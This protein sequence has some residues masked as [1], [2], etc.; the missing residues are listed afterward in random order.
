LRCIAQQREL[1]PMERDAEKAKWE[2]RRAEDAA[3][4][5]FLKDAITRAKSETAAVERRK[6]EDELAGT[7]DGIF[8]AE[9]QAE[10][11][12]TWPDE[13]TLNLYTADMKRFTAWARER[14][15][16]ALPAQGTTVAAFL[17]EAA[18]IDE[19]SKVAQMK[20]A[21][22]R[23]RQSVKAILFT[24]RVAQHWIDDGPIN[25]VLAFIGAKYVEEIQAQEKSNG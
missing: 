13:V 8:G 19:G 18:V 23:L 20:E 22:G 12:R 7:I 1:T 21:E 24:H 5:L 9:L 6:R 25:A 11:A 4:E 15:I 16:G 14:G 2:K 3:F 17:L 10:H